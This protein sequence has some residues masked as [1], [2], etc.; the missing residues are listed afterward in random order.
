MFRNSGGGIS[1]VVDFGWQTTQ[2]NRHV[3]DGAFCI[4]SVVRRICHLGLP[5]G[6]VVKNLPANAGD[7]FDTWIGKFP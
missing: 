6:S 3:G 4:R 5:G 7:K 1:A 2:V